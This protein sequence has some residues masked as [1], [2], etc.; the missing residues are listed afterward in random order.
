MSK[1]LEDVAI[2]MLKERNIIPEKTGKIYYGQDN[3]ILPVYLNDKVYYFKFFTQPNKDTLEAEIKFTEF[4]RGNGV[5]TPQYYKQ[6]EK[7]I[8]EGELKSFKTIFYASE[9]IDADIEPDMTP[10]LLIDIIRN[11]AMMHK[12]TKKFDKTSI[13]IE[14]KTTYQKLMQYYVSKK[15]FWKE[16]GFTDIIEKVIEMGD[17]PKDTYPIHA[18]LHTGNIMI[19]NNKVKAFIDFGDIRE[20]YFEDD[21]GKVF[22]NLLGAK[23][24]SIQ[25]IKRLMSFY[26]NETGYELSRK[27]I[28]ISTV[29]QILERF[30]V[31]TLEEENPE[32]TDKVTRIL[33]DLEVEIDKLREEPVV[34]N[35]NS[36]KDVEGR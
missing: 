35:D 26:E 12:Q 1:V 20:S 28:Y 17:E 11:I 7:N 36:K 6:G 16:Y 24:I 13:N 8:F 31:K 25:G 27:N 29:Y 23:G 33:K 9:H 18:D 15:D 34:G 10:E 30:Y 22:Q 2:N 3:F 5:N 21:L 19:E 32:Y 14:K 4:L